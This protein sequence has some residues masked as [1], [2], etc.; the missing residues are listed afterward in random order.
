[1][2]TRTI[3][4]IWC[5]WFTKYL[6]SLVDV[7]RPPQNSGKSVVWILL[8]NFRILETQ[9][10]ILSTAQV[11]KITVVSIQHSE[12]WETW[13]AIRL[14]SACDMIYRPHAGFITT[15]SWCSLSAVTVTRSKS[16]PPGYWSTNPGTPLGPT[17]DLRQCKT[18][19]DTGDAGGKGNF[20][21]LA[22]WL[23]N[24]A[25]KKLNRHDSSM[26]RELKYCLPLHWLGRV[27][28]ERRL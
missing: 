28:R 15:L 8:T 26:A 24:N 3:C 25:I 5:W 6:A 19:G 22:P 9:T 21:S 4:E 13:Q 14:V 23:T 16:R 18:M 1:M 20:Q 7:L 12:C 11:N 17:G 10:V 27:I 2:T